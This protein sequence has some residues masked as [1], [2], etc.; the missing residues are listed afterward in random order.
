MFKAGSKNLLVI[1]EPKR[2]RVVKQFV[3]LNLKYNQQLKHII[4]VVAKVFNAPIACVT[5]IDDETQWIKI[6]KGLHFDKTPRNLSFCIYTVKRKSIHVVKDTLNDP[7]FSEHPFVVNHPKI[8]FYAG[9]PLITQ[10]GHCIGALCVMDKKTHIPTTEQKMSLKSLAL[11]VS[12]IMELKLTI[13]QLNYSLTNLKVIQKNKSYNEIKLRAMFESLPDA[14]FLLGKHGEVLDFNKIA[15][16]QIQNNYLTKLSLGRTINGFLN[17]EFKETF[18]YHFDDALK[19]NASNLEKLEGF[20]T[21]DKLWWECRFEPVIN[22]S[23]E[24]I[25]VSY[26]AKDINERKLHELKILN[27]KK[28]LMRIAQIQS[29][30]YRGPVSSILGMMILIESENYVASKEYLMMLH[31]ATKKLEEKINEVVNLVNNNDL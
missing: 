30:D 19:G 5:L 7:R 9:Y 31:T 25:G 29:H 11:S 4:T 1:N 3:S 24:I 18:L 20:I 22:D 23:D 16:R 13:E 8:R 14:Y 15:Y 17:P 21:N 2:I 27:Q 6:S 10:A 12:N 26:T 28:L